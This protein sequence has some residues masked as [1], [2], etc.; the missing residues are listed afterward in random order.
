MDPFAL[1]PAALLLGAVSSK[2]IARLQYARSRTDICKQ[3]ARMMSRPVRGN[4]L[5]QGTA[6]HDDA[7]SRQA[8]RPAWGVSPRGDGVHRELC[9]GR[10]PAANRVGRN[11]EFYLQ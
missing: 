7:G 4:A 8:R 11:C 9:G 5:V 6:G 10:D 3:E 1:R 2:F